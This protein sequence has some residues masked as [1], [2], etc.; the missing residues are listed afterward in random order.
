MKNTTATP[1]TTASRTHNQKVSTAII[2]SQL[3]T[4]VANSA[5]TNAVIA[6][7]TRLNLDRH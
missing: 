3:Y 2:W 7:A 4:A 6:N 1:A 5:I